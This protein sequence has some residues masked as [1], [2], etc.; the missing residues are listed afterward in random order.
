M[1][2]T[3]KIALT[4]A[5]LLFSM[6]GACAVDCANLKS[7]LAKYNPDKKAWAEVVLSK[8]QRTEALKAL[9]APHEPTARELDQIILS[10]KKNLETEFP[11]Y[12]RDNFD[13]CTMRRSELKIA[14]LK[15]ASEVSV[16]ARE[17]KEIAKEVRETLRVRNQFP[18]LITALANARVLEF[19]VTGRVWESADSTRIKLLRTKIEADLAQENAT[20]GEPWARVVKKLEELKSDA[21]RTKFLNQSDDF[22]KLR[23][24]ILAEPDEAEAYLSQLRLL[25]DSA[26]TSP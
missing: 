26:K 15:T 5:V 7:Q 14:L 19:G 11:A 8:P 13:N 10:L 12:L 2:M 3:E 20:F 4:L 23:A 25:A 17:R 22:K 9:L 1:P 24:H 21:E 16:P 6:S 18:T